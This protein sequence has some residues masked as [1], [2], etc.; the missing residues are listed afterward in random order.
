MTKIAIFVEGQ[1]EMLFVDRLIQEIAEESGLAVEHAEAIGGSIR[2][3]QIRVLKRITLQSHHKFYVLIVNSAGDSN[4]KSDIIE[5]YY[6]LNYRLGSGP[7]S[8]VPEFFLTG[9]AAMAKRYPRGVP[10][11]R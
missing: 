4:V 3:R 1:T 9:N 11:A 6:S 5:R 2:A 10:W 7:D 8:A